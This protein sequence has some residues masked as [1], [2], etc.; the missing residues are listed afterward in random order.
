MLLTKSEAAKRL[1]ISQGTVDRYRAR[2]I[3]QAIKL[4]AKVLFREET[5]DQVLKRHERKSN[6]SV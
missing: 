4:G 5:L 6:R 3:L 2:G 1:R